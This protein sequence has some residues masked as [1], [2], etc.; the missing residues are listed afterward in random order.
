[1]NIYFYS[2]II[3]YVI[4]FTY[5]F[6]WDVFMDWGLIDPKAPKDSP[7]LREEMIF[8]SKWYYYLAIVQDGVLRLSWVRQ[9]LM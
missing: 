8:G 9:L 4:S 2:W 3:A 7:F 1:M 5:T 6:L